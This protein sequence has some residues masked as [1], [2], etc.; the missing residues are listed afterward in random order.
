MKNEYGAEC[1]TK[2]NDKYFFDKVAQPFYGKVSLANGTQ[3]NVACFEVLDGA[4]DGRLFVGIE[5]HGCYTFGHFTH[6]SYAM[7]KLNL[8][9][10]DAR[11]MSDFINS[12]VE[13]FEHQQGEVDERYL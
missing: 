11:A 2:I 10:S 6:F 5:G 1:Y 4:Q 9:E 3:F 12:Q 7:E 13:N 8:R